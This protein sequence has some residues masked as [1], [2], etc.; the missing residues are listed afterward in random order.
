MA[1]PSDIQKQKIRKRLIDLEGPIFAIL[2]RKK[3]NQNI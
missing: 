3:H 2:A 1:L